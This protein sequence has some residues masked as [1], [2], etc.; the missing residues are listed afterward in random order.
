MGI[1]TLVVMEIPITGVFWA[2]SCALR[3]G[4]VA[5]EDLQC[6]PAKLRMLQITLQ[7]ALL[8][9]V[10]FRFTYVVLVFF[11]LNLGELRLIFANIRRIGLACV[12][13]LPSLSTR[14]KETGRLLSIMGFFFC[15]ELLVEWDEKAGLSRV[16]LL[17]ALSL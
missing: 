13:F 15:I 6:V 12:T 1:C 4:F 17:A 5:L 3:I 11:F 2:A 9:L 10:E 7:D 14:C 16:S 8:A